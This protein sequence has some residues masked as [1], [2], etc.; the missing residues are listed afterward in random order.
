MGNCSDTSDT[1]HPNQS[2]QANTNGDNTT[3]NVQKAPTTNTTA[4]TTT[5]NTQNVTAT[6]TTKP[7]QTTTPV[8]KT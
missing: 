5:Q 4:N 1:S 8:T 3:P 2:Q 7:A 6:T